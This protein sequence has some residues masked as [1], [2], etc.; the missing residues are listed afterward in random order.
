MD[1]QSAGDG[2]ELAIDDLLPEFRRETQTHWS[3]IAL[4]LGA[5]AA[6]LALLP[7][8]TEGGMKAAIFIVIFGLFGVG[9]LATRV[10]RRHEALV[11]PLIAR[12]AGLRY[13]QGQDGFLLKLP[14]RMLPKGSVRKCNDL[15]T[16]T[17]GGREIS[18]AEVMI[19]T[20]GKNS[21]V[22]FQGIVAEF[23]NVVPMPSFFVAAEKETRGWFMFKGN[24]RVDDLNF[25]QTVQGREDLYGVWTHLRS[26]AERPGFE[27]L[28]G[29]LLELEGKLPSAR[30]YS[31]SSDGRVTHVALRHSRDLFR[32][33]GLFASR[34]RL[35]A[36][37]RRAFEDLRL[38]L[39]VVTLL[40]AA[41]ARV[42]D[43]SRRST[44]RQQGEPA[45]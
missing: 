28:L 44:A 3:L 41:E 33:G 2:T 31:A 45:E 21:T 16:G 9:A 29:A 1:D 38:P 27:A 13:R 34:D 10:R 18:F 36:Q 30:L 17:V 25:I 42:L 15:V 22:Q 23:P 19:A 26:E 12:S 14:P 35:D 20:G 32:L 8:D 4:I 6:S 43:A 11:V 24:L 39:E 40:L 37:I 5:G 7:L